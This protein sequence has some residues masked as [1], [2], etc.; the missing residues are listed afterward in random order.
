MY[1]PEEKRRDAEQLL[2]IIGRLSVAETPDALL[3]VLAERLAAL[4]AS[5]A[6]FFYLENNKQGDPEWMEA[7]AN[8]DNDLTSLPPG[9]RFYL[10]KFPFARMLLSTPLNPFYID[11]VN[12]NPNIDT[13]SREV[14][15]QLGVRTTLVLPLYHRNQWAGLINVSWS[16]VVRLSD[17]EI[18][19]LAVVTRQ[20]A[21]FV[22]ALSQI[23]QNSRRAAQLDEMVTLSSELIGTADVKEGFFRYLNPA[24]EG[25]L[26]YTRDELWARPFA[27]FI[28]VDDRAATLREIERMLN[29]NVPIN[30][31]AVR[32]L[33][34]DGQVQYFTWSA[35]PSG[36]ANVV[37][38]VAQNTTA[39]RRV[40]ANLARRAL[41]LETVS[42]VSLAV[43]NILDL[44]MLLQ[45]LADLTQ[46]SF[47]L[48]HINIFLLDEKKNTLNLAA[49]SGDA[50]RQLRADKHKIALSDNVAVV[51]NAARSKSAVVVNNIADLRGYT[52]L[53]LLP[54]LRS[55]MA[56]PILSGNVLIGV[57]D[58]QA[59]V[60]N[61]FD[62]EDVRVKSAL[63]NQIAIGVQNAQAFAGMRQNEAELKEAP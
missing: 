46:S 33:S 62:N 37:S 10:P 42:K 9:T 40:E 38:F 45:S 24:W 34:R 54:N 18:E 48:Y 17:A 56:I 1:Q 35:K 8:W 58:V 6:A 32:F 26:G 39:Q 44:D 28:H 61:R 15:R 55:Q 51:A 2:E 16:R 31:L 27:Q 21:P 52:A 11:D 41:E 60:L 57:L 63:A 29:F 19:T 23:T 5:T 20:M 43:A 53:A 49:G 13:A 14:Y 3:E 47:G 12:T 25:V 36:Q 30:N 7:V 4:E 22:Y 59:N 50:G